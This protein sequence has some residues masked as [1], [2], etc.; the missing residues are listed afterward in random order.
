MPDPQAVV[1]ETEGRMLEREQNE[2]DVL[3]IGCT[4]WV[5]V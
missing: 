5:Q 2:R 1:L 4:G 3:A